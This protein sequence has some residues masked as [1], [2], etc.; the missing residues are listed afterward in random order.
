M[1][2]TWLVTSPQAYVSPQSSRVNL[3]HLTLSQN[4]L[5]LPLSLLDVPPP[6]SCLSSLV[7][8]FL[9]TSDGSNTAMRFSLE[10]TISAVNERIISYQKQ[11]H[12]VCS[13]LYVCI[14]GRAEQSVFI[15]LT[16]CLLRHSHTLRWVFMGSKGMGTLTQ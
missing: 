12:H 11:C 2:S 5:F 16:G 13:Q 9:L 10:S 14:N 6:I 4:P 7:I 3:L 1:S 8:G 15:L